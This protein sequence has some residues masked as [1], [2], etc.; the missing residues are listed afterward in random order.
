MNG[1]NGPIKDPDNLLERRICDLGLT[2]TGSR[3]EKSLD[4]LRRELIRKKITRW[5]PS[6]YLTDEWGCPSGQP[7]IGV[8]FYL[9]DPRLAAINR[10]FDDLEDAREIMMFL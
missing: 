6:F 3:V 10:Q 7:I 5:Q 1:I 4:R 9:A 8:P 2:L